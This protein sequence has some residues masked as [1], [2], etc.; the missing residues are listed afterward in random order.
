MPHSDMDSSSR[1]HA[2]QWATI[3]AAALA[4]GSPS[5]ASSSPE[6]LNAGRSNLS[7]VASATILVRE[8]H[9]R[10][11]GRGPFEEYLVSPPR[12]IQLVPPTNDVAGLLVDIGLPPGVYDEVRLEATSGAVVLS[13]QAHVAH[14]HT[15]TTSLGTL[16]LPSAAQSGI[17][18]RI[19]PS[20]HV[21]TR[22]SPELTLVLDL[23]DTFVFNGPPTHDPGVKRVV[24]TPVMPAANASTH[25]RITLRAAKESETSLCAGANEPL[26]G[27][28]VTAID[29][30]RIAPPVT[31]VTDAAGQAWLPLLPGVYD[32]VLT[33]PDYEPVRIEGQTVFV[34]NETSLG[35][36][37]LVRPVTP[38][39]FDP[40]RA[41]LLMIMANIAYAD[42]TGRDGDLTTTPVGAPL[43]RTGEPYADNLRSEL[44]DY[45]DPCWKLVDYLDVDEGVSRTQFFI[46]RHV[47]RGDLVVSF[48]GTSESEDWLTDAY[49]LKK[50]WVLRDGAVV[51]NSVH[52]GIHD[53]YLHA[54]GPL[55]SALN[56]AIAT[57]APNTSR[58]RV[59]F[60]GHSLGG[61]LATLAALDMADYLVATH[62]YA[63]DNIIMYSYGAPRTITERLAPVL[64]RE[65]PNSFGVAAKDDL[66]THVPDGENGP[67]FDNE[68][69]QIENLVV[70]SSNIPNVE[71]D[72]DGRYQDLR[73]TRVERSAGRLYKGCVGLGGRDVPVGYGTKGHERVQYIKRLENIVDGGIPAVWLD[74]DDDG[75]LVMKWQGGVQGPCDWVGLY[76]TE[77]TNPPTPPADANDYLGLPFDGSEWVVAGNGYP[78]GVSSDGT[79]KD[80]SGPFDAGKD[81]WIGYVDGFDRLIRTV[82]YTGPRDAPAA[83]S[84]GVV[85]VPAL[86]AASP[87]PAVAFTT[88]RF[89]LPRTAQVRATV[90]DVAGRMVRE[91]VRGPH[92]S[93]DHAVP[94]DLRDASGNP[95]GAGVYF[96]RFEAEEQRIVRPVL[97]RR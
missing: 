1:H 66:V 86:A 72:G 27:L 59:Y 85:R 69:T 51:E 34:A 71:D 77:A 36:V 41:I 79:G 12:D 80:P 22:L 57:Y 47:S 97:V 31:T 19:D 67:L 81:F 4:V 45:L 44:A 54:A 30:T 50:D 74:L 20:I 17:K 16:H 58:A 56:E 89:T 32:I 26:P 10:R 15:F 73:E 6:A 82:R 2:A 78:Y 84:A 14:G 63:R 52:A 96:V 94:W 75:D 13:D 3:V 88:F 55:Q 11:D 28:L 5:L 48:R 95:V 70:L 33:A 90:C 83:G 25:G 39:A 9:V 40:D 23:D 87:N 68:F 8:V 18:L 76:A 42:G 91:L 35:E 93:G 64:T 24:L 37:I 60:T 7:Y 62:G 61:G 46:A 43:P 38:V 29:R 21:V 65:V 92:E 53:A 49:A